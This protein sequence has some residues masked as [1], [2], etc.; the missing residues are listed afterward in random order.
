MGE[1]YAFA[2]Q[3][4][5]LRKS[6]AIEAPSFPRWASGSHLTLSQVGSIIRPGRCEIIAVALSQVD[7]GAM[8]LSLAL[9]VGSGGCLCQLGVL[10]V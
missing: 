1:L 10:P 3:R 4:T 5:V 9:T 7:H 8:V 6:H 2:L